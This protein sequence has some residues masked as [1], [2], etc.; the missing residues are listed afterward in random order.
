MLTA[1]RRGVGAEGP[2]RQG[3]GRWACAC[4]ARRDVRVARAPGVRGAATG[5]APAGGRRARGG[6]RATRS[7]AGRCG[8][9]PK[10]G[11][12]ERRAAKARAVASA[13]PPARR[14]PAL[15]TVSLGPGS[16]RRLAA[17]PPCCRRPRSSRGGGARTCFLF[18]AGLHCLLASPPGAP[19]SALHLSVVPEYK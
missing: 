9:A 13:P 5:W 19:F 6:L 12:W 1:G 10:P 14:R 4:G 17:R 11:L 7:R 16:G 2:A 15:R 18:P 3:A 8:A